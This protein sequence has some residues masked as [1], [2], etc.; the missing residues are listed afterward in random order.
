MASLKAFD[1]TWSIGLAVFGFHILVL[2]FLV[3]KSGYVPKILGILLIIAF[4]GYSV[5]GFIDP[6]L[7][8]HEN[9]RTLI[10]WVFVVPMVT[11]EVGLGLWLLVKGGKRISLDSRR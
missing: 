4:F 6:L 10:E 5:T 11:G 9:Y 1:N 3:L 7:P 2:G 8:D